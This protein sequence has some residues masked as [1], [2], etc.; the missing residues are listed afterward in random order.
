MKTLLQ[1]LVPD[2]SRVRLAYH[3]TKALIAAISE[4]FPAKKL[5]VIG[6]TGTDGKTTT[7][8]MI[9]HMLNACGLKTGAL[10]TAFF[11]VGREIR[12]NPT[13]KTSPSPFLVQKFL[14]ELVHSGCT[15]AVIECSSHGLLQGRVNYTY[16]AVAG[17]TNVSEE[18]LDY[19]R[20]MERYIEAKAILFRMLGGKGTKVLHATDQSYG[21]L[22][23][24]ASERTITYVAEAQGPSH[25]S[26]GDISL[27]L[28]M[29]ESHA[30]KSRA[31]LEAR[32][33]RA[34][35]EYPLT[36]SI[37]GTFNLENALCAIG[38]LQG[39]A[40]PP[41]ITSALRALALFRGIQGRM[42]RLDVGQNF[43]VYIDFTVTP[44]S[45]AATLATL[46]SMLPDGKR[47]LV[48]A[49]SCGDRMKEKR[50]IIGK[51]LSDHADIA[52]IT[53]EDP[54]TEDPEKIIDEVLSG[55]PSGIQ[56]FNQISTEPFLKMKSLNKFC[57]RISD[58]LQAIRFIL[59]Q[60]Q[61]GDIVIVCGKGSD[62]TM[63]TKSGQIPW[64]ERVIVQEALKSMKHE[65]GGNKSLYRQQTRESSAAALG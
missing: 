6:V 14:R 4:G 46:K 22:A 64:N 23:R 62:T 32:S 37:A 57:V 43:S 45:Y 5:I 58:R 19:H 61:E 35:S 15:H 55:V 17:I 63:M 48:L 28:R 21:T 36:I 27:S 65:N 39:L 54:Y 30:Q 18:H 31:V 3:R 26:D 41:E 44:K 56:I 59:S 40:H 60:A 2:T 51:I 11:Q 9:A 38:C 20:T 33:A 24:I 10:S 53:N 8:G 50:P 1:W 12:W 49:G 16:P 47:L 7:V 29:I 34:T 13:Q 25:L 42:E 52:V